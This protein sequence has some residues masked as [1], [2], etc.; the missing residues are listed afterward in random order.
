M[1]RIIEII[2]S[3]NGQTRLKTNGFAGSACQ[4]ASR[5]L[6]QALGVKQSEQLTAEFHTQQTDRQVLA[7]K[8]V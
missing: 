4:E 6:E 3:P 5:S 7:Q 1:T 8:S 2:I